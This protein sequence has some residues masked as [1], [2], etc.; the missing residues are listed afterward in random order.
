LGYILSDFFTNS[1]GHPA[2]A[3]ILKESKNVLKV[4]GEKWA[5]VSIRPTN[6]KK[7]KPKMPKRGKQIWSQSYVL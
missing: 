1:S 3:A 6:N 7:T 5:K 4:I 2:A